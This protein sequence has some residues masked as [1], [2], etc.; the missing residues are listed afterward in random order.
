MSDESHDKAKRLIAAARV[1]GIPAAD[2]EW[3]DAHLE[4]CGDCSARARSVEKSITALR[5]ASVPVD[6]CLIDETRKRVHLR[7]MEMRK[8]AEQTKALWISC[9]L[10]W[11]FGVVSAP[12]LWEGL[13]WIDQ[14]L[15]LPQAVGWVAFPILWIVPAVLIGM[16]FAWKRSHAPSENGYTAR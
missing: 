15:A 16:G 13:K 5:L 6:P 7:A 11:V 12:L 1:E 10:S 2:R 8:D 14:R 9:A 4:T 3:L